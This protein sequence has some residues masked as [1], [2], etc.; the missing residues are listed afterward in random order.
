M[1]AT[2]INYQF[3]QQNAKSAYQQLFVKGTRIPARTLY[4]LHVCSEPL[5]PEEIA[6][7]YSIP[8]DAVRE[9]ITYCESNPPELQDDH[10]RDEELAKATGMTA[11]DYKNR[12][13]P[14]PLSPQEWS[15]INRA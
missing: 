13:V 11:P 10:R 4:G 3:L 9:A 7:D 14:Q 15:R 8:V 5:T 6:A 12:P 2:I 1:S